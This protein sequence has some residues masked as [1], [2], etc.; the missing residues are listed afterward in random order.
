MNATIGIM[1]KRI[2]S[3]KQSFSGTS[4]ACVMKDPQSRSTPTFLVT[5]APMQK[6]NYMSFNGWYYWIDDVISETNNMYR[7]RAHVD[8]LATWKSAIAG[9]KAFVNFGPVGYWN[10]EII[11][12]RLRPDQIEYTNVGT[13]S[14]SCF[15]YSTGCV[16]IRILSLDSGAGEG[17][18]QTLCGSMT[19][20]RALLDDYAQGLDT[21]LSNITVDF[22]KLVGKMAGLGNA[23]DSIISAVWIPFKLSDISS[24]VGAF[25]NIGGYNLSGQW[26]WPNIWAGALM[27]EHDLLIVP[28]T[29]VTDYPWLAHPNYMNVQLVTPGGAY[30]ISDPIFTNYTAPV[31]KT[32]LCYTIDGDCTLYVREKNSKLLLATSSWNASID[33]KNFV[34]KSPSVLEAGIQAGLKVG[35]MA[36]GLMSVGGAVASSTGTLVA[37]AG[38]AKGSERAMNAGLNMASMGEGMNIDNKT[39]SAGI[40]G[41]F[42]GIDANIG[43]K[44]CGAPSNLSNI[45]VNDNKDTINVIQ[46]LFDPNIIANGTYEDFCDRY[47]YP[48]FTYETLSGGYY[49]CAGAS[50]IADAPQSE[51]ATINSF[52]NSG[53]YVE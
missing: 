14:F 28:G 20:F 44:Q 51:L 17:G 16:I 9:T 37:E 18:I 24:G 43:V 26:Y 39:L 15:D 48:N 7:I 50:V 6:A 19:S 1:T 2:N 49:E 5:G 45:Y 10:K 12:P 34:Y 3:T 47:G 23:L 42:K 53:I 32:R 46:V 33:L 27:E 13:Q 40:E 21:D 41:A 52:C 25:A 8:P 4:H 36:I 30:D 29:I 31:L 22:E 38:L 35:S 11:D